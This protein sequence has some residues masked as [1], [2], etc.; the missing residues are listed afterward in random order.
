MKWAGLLA[1]CWAVY[2]AVVLVGEMVVL[3][4]VGWAVEEREKDVNG[5]KLTHNEEGQGLL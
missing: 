2:W 1:V 5:S 3:W 4:V